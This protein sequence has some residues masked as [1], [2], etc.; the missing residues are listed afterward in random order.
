MGSNAQPSFQQAVAS[1]VMVT[2]PVPSDAEVRITF[3]SL[4]AADG[5]E[6]VVVLTPGDRETIDVWIGNVP[7]CEAQSHDERPGCHSESIDSHFEL[8]YGLSR[9]PIPFAN[10]L[11]PHQ[12]NQPSFVRS[13]AGT[14]PEGAM[15][16]RLPVYSSEEEDEKCGGKI[17]MDWKACTGLWLNNP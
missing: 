13:S 12:S 5:K 16:C 8:Y 14:Q 1:A 9:A 2:V 3:Q 11:V 4:V 6:K 17:P 15:S 10:R 7:F